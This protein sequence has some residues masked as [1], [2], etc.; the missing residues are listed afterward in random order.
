MKKLPIIFLSTVLSFVVLVGFNST[1]AQEDV[2]VQE[3]LEVQEEI[4][5]PEEQEPDKGDKLEGEKAEADDHVRELLDLDSE[6]RLD[7][8]DD[9]SPRGDDDKQFNLRYEHP[10]GRINVNYNYDEEIIT[11]LNRT[12]FEDDVNLARVTLDE[13]EEKAVDSLETLYPD[14]VSE[15][16]VDTDPI[17]NRNLDGD[18]RN[19]QYEFTF[20]RQYD[21]IPVAGDEISIQVDAITGEVSNV[22]KSFTDVDEIHSMDEEEA[23][24]LEEAE[25]IM[26][27]DFPLELIYSSPHDENELDEPKLLFTHFNNLSS[28][29]MGNFLRQNYMVDA[30]SGELVSSTFDE[31]HLE[32]EELL[33]DK[34]AMGEELLSETVIERSASEMDEI[35]RD[36]AEETAK[37]IVEKAGFQNLELESVNEDATTSSRYFDE[38]QKVFEVVFES[39][40]L[41]ERRDIRVEICQDTGELMGLD[42]RMLRGAGEG[43]LSD[44]LAEADEL[45]LLEIAN[46]FME[47]LP[48][49]DETQILSQR[50][51]SSFISEETVADDMDLIENPQEQEL[52]GAARV[53]EYVELQDGVPITNSGY[54]V[55]VDDTG[56]ISEI[57][58]IPAEGDYPDY[59]DRV[60]VSLKEAQEKLVSEIGA[61]LVYVQERI[62]EDEF[63]GMPDDP[64]EY[65][66]P[67]I[68]LRPAYQLVTTPD[69][70]NDPFYLGAE[71]GK[72]YDE[73]LDDMDDEKVFELVDEDHWA[74][75]YLELALAQDILPLKDGELAPNEEITREEMVN[76]L[77][78][79]LQDTSRLDVA[80]EPHFQDI[81]TDHDKFEQVQF[82]AEQEVFNETEQ[83]RPEQEITREEMAEIVVKALDLEVIVSDGFDYHL[84]ITDAEEISADYLD[85]VAITTGLEIMEG[86]GEEFEPQDYL[87][88]AE[89]LTVLYR[90]DDT[91]TD[92]Y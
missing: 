12:Q 14:T 45:H 56:I 35:N 7:D 91:L 40:K 42:S 18:A 30:S 8:I 39:E 72:I 78:F 59:E 66:Q 63:D 32:L 85:Y 46:E 57:S 37:Q 61:E 20:L 60:D 88:R 28:G 36:Y 13:A 17:V 92:M 31:S 80:E 84:D 67:K 24:E 41:P 15:E 81:D 87:T 73:K 9:R 47:E 52:G 6:Y 53:Y 49:K 48:F 79:M 51:L 2:E 65:E 69:Q 25:D 75:D 16:K 5:E 10:E 76:G 54:E 3:E 58:R 83:F 71:T 23:V 44:E 77:T 50:E 74:S 11:H 43:L 33:T 86:N 89:A 1:T 82:L 38:E 21:G 4:E 62:T 68:E 22:R 64:D 29:A 26:R 19:S 34:G 70:G 55:I 27:E 90:I